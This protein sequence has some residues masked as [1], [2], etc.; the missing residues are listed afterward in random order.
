LVYTI[1][2]IADILVANVSLHQ[3]ATVVEHL[4]T[5][6]RRISFPST[7]VFFALETERRDAHIF[8]KEVYERGVRNFIVKIGYHANEF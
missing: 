2:H 7:T 6:S 8:I 5:D 3:P 4:S 1:Q